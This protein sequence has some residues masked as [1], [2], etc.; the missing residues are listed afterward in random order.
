MSL[1]MSRKLID[2]TSLKSL[3]FDYI[4]L[5]GG[6]SG[7]TTACLF[8]K[9]GFRTLI[10]SEVFPH[11]DSWEQNRS[12]VPSWYAM[13][14]AYPHFLEIKDMERVMQ[15]TQDFFLDLH[16][17]KIPGLYIYKM[18]EIFENS[19]N[20]SLP[21]AS[22]RIDFRKEALSKILLG[23]SDESSKEVST[24]SFDTVF[25]NMPEYMQFL[26][27]YY[28]SLGGRLYRKNI[29][30][31]RELKEFDTESIINCMGFSGARIFHDKAPARIV[32]GRLVLATPSKIL[33]DEVYTSAYN[34][35]PSSAY[36]KKDGS[37]EYLH[38]FPRTDGILLGQTRE[39]GTVDED[40]L[41]W[42]GIEVL[43]EEFEIDGIK[44]PQSVITLNETL[45]SGWIGEKVRFTPLKGMCGY[46]YYRAPGEG[47]VRL[48]REMLEGKIIYHN[49]GHG[50][51]GV[52]ASWGCSAEI[53]RMSINLPI[54]EIRNRFFDN[55]SFDDALSENPF[56]IFA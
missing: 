36:L 37:P 14:S 38:Y 30:S 7:I 23:E 17:K 6:I 41:S 50:G 9:L 22:M 44:I 13:A 46:R 2:G 47:G 56:G 15:G 21:L 24:Y 42:S 53:A 39:I 55:V 3:S 27:R 28:L 48:D 45:V 16:K 20:E 19:H 31:T 11:I 10:V 12:L 52:T 26:Y 34:Y 1:S 32:R 43:D 18:H 33:P 5:G 35:Y 4:I 40:T 25:V 54:D 29:N 8:Q 49:F 51:S